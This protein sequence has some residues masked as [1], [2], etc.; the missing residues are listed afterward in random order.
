[1]PIQLKESRPNIYWFPLSINTWNTIGGKKI[2][3]NVSPREP[4]YMLL[5]TVFDVK[6]TLCSASTA[7]TVRVCITACAEE[8]QIVRSMETRREKDTFLS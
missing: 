4:Y 1:M 6:L 5:L 8:H 2:S 7:M 3:F